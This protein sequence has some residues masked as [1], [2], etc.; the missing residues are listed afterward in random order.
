VTMESSGFFGGVGP[1]CDPEALLDLGL[2]NLARM[3]PHVAD[4]D[5]DADFDAGLRIV[6][7]GILAGWR[8][9]AVGGRSAR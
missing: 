2:P 6:E 7:Q 5:V 4:R 9:G 8:A 1:Y 3:A